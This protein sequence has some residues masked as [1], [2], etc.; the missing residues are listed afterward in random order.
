M[1]DASPVATQE[2]ATVHNPPS[3]LAL[4]A[5]AIEKGNSPADLNA[6]LDFAER[7]KKDAAAE[8]FAKALAGF[9]SEIPHILKERSVSFKGGV[10]T[11]YKFASYDDIKRV[12]GPY[13]K[14]WGIVTT[15]TAPTFA[16]QLLVGT[17]R[18]RVGTHYEDTT[19]PIPIPQ[20]MNTNKAQDFGGAIKYLQR[21]LFCAALDIVTTDEDDDGAG[22]DDFISGEEVATINAAI[23]AAEKA[24]HPFKLAKFLGWLNVESLDKLTRKDLP[25]ALDEL[26]RAKERAL[27]KK[28][29]KP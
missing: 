8:A 19:L 22:L 1:S 11:M 15:F 18:V 9:Q 26:K 20:G 16:N 21:Y 23:E 12:I 17:I 7:V 14:K 29:G 10:G 13:Q 3:P 6:L 27:E 4:V 2:L 25:K 28:A 24:G 5:Q